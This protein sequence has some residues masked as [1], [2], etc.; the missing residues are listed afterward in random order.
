L[1]VA[2]VLSA[3][4]KA[5]ISISEFLM[6]NNTERTWL[7]LKGKTTPLTTVAEHTAKIAVTGWSTVADLVDYGIY[8]FE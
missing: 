7:I 4:E 5:N 1:T 3:T 2:D 8:W 6:K